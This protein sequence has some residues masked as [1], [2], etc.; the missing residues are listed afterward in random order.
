MIK[1][2]KSSSK[3][4]NILGRKPISSGKNWNRSAYTNI[5]PRMQQTNN[6]PIISRNLYGNNNINNNNNPSLNNNNLNIANNNYNNNNNNINNKYKNIG[7]PGV[8]QHNNYNSSNN[9]NFS[10][11]KQKPISKTEK[12]DLQ[13]RLSRFANIETGVSQENVGA[14]LNKTDNNPALSAN[15]LRL[16]LNDKNPALTANDLR[17]KLN[18]KI[19]KKSDEKKT[20]KN[21]E[22][23]QQKNK[24]VGNLNSNASAFTDKN[25]IKDLNNVENFQYSNANNISSVMWQ[26][27]TDFSDK[28]PNRAILGST[29]IY[30]RSKKNNENKF[31]QS[32]TVTNLINNR[33]TR[34]T[35]SDETKPTNKENP[36]SSNIYNNNNNNRL[37]QSL[38]FT[39][40][41][42]STNVPNN[43]PL[44]VGKRSLQDRIT[45]NQNQ[46]LSITIQTNKIGRSVSDPAANNNKSKATIT[47]I[48]QPLQ[49]ANKTTKE[50]NKKPY[51][52]LSNISKNEN[53]ENN[54]IRELETL[55]QK[56]GFKLP[57]YKSWKLKNTGR[58]HC[59]VMVFTSSFLF[60]YIFLIKFLTR[61]MVQVIHHIRTIF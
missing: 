5:Q 54:A 24:N 44:F 50:P 51:E 33:L 56:N 59:R 26:K 37:N 46:S 18:D 20:H 48:E 45:I 38:L 35:S 15:D 42:E 17:L 4:K 36:S 39:I 47:E 34:T 53:Y 27:N 29:S 55:C 49:Q 32:S 60:V 9:Y 13:N 41:N 21:E 19:E 61:L 23:F 2:Q 11:N 25:R 10:S 7:K 28:T 31:N 1:R 52:Q 6:R 16:K 57:E 3:G 30:I 14:K 22:K 58:Y 43:L 12:I 8:T 40:H